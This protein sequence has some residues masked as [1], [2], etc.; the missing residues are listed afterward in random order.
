MN[1]GT[2]PENEGLPNCALLRIAAE[3][4]SLALIMKFDF[5]IRFTKQVSTNGNERNFAI[6]RIRSSERTKT[7]C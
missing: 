4:R 6:S 5:E 7:I 2:Q 1:Q 3:Y